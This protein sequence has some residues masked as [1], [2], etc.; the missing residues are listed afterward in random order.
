[1]KLYAESGLKVNWVE[2]RSLV[3]VPS[4]YTHIRFDVWEPVLIVG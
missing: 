1:V 4:M 3:V 2:L